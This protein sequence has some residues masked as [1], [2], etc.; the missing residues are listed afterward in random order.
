[1]KVG[2]KVM[3]PFFL[4]KTIITIVINITC[5][6]CRTASFTKLRLFSRNVSFVVNTLFTPSLETAHA[7]CLNSLMKRR[8][9]SVRFVSTYQS[10]QN[11]RPHGPYFTETK[12]MGFEVVNQD[13]S[14]IFYML[15]LQEWLC[16]MKVLGKI[17]HRA[18]YG[19]NSRW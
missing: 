7:G 3:P 11:R 4:S 13:V 2:T 1:M 16:Q 12:K 19:K 6:M 14:V 9:C 18:W 17:P 8:G 15:L 5:I 10:P